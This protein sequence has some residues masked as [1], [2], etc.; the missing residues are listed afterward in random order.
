VA[1]SDNHGLFVRHEGNFAL[2]SGAGN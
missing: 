1:P 2:Q